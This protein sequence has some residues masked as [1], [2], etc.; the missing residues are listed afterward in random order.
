MAAADLFATRS[1]MPQFRCK[2]CSDT[3]LVELEG[4]PPAQFAWQAF[5][6]MMPCVCER[7]DAIRPAFEA[8]KADYAKGAK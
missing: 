5:A 4:I 1:R 6:T 2:T 7:G 8:G 3:G